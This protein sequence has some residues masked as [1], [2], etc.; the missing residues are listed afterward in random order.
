MNE[1]IVIFIFIAWY[2]LSLVVSET[3]GKR[4]QIGVQWSFFISILFSP[5]VGYIATKISP[6][7]LATVK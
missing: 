7:A 3:I 5:V 6:K 1:Y 4:R 2:T